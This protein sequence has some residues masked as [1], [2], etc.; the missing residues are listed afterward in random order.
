MKKQ[1][2]I[3]PSPLKR[4]KPVARGFF[5]AALVGA[6]A[7]RVLPVDGATMSWVQLANNYWD[8][9]TN[10]S[11][12]IVPGTNDVAIIN[13]QGGGSQN[14]VVIRQPV[15]V[16][17]LSLAMNVSMETGGSLTIA[18]GT[19]DC[20]MNTMNNQ[21]V[22]I[23]G[24][25]NIA[26]N[27]VLNVSV[28]PTLN[29]TLVNAGTVNMAASLMINSGRIINLPQA[30]F[31]MIG[32]LPVGIVSVGGVVDFSNAGVLR[33]S[34]NAE[35]AF[36]NQNFA[37]TNNGLVKVE[38]GR[39][40]I[41]GPGRSDG[42][43]DAATGAS[44]ELNNYFTFE[45]SHQFSGGGTNLWSS[46]EVWVYGELTG[47]QFLLGPGSTLMSATNNLGGRLI[48]TGGTIGLDSAQAL[49]IEPGGVLSIGGTVHLKGSITNAGTVVWSG[50]NIWLDSGSAAV[51]CNQ[52][53][54]VFELRNTGGLLGS[55][56]SLFYNA[57]LVR[58]VAVK[59]NTLIDG[60]RFVN[61]GTLEVVTG[62]LTVVGGFDGAGGV[63]TFGISSPTDYGWIDF[64]TGGN[65]PLAGSLS[66]NLLNGYEPDAGT[67]FPVVTFGSKSGAFT[68][69]T[70]LFVGSGR[71][72]E[73]VFTST[74]LNLVAH[75]T[76]FPAIATD[77][78]VITNGQCHFNYVGTP[79]RVCEVWVSTNLP[80]F[81]LLQ[82]L[83]NSTGTLP[84]TD[85]VTNLPQR[86]YQ[87]RE[88]Q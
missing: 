38:S 71:Y 39:L 73:P 11:P 88:Q 16:G 3:T 62:P 51:L 47:S 13:Y 37:F 23:T 57:G 53:Q 82:T 58:K 26:S 36:I 10:W 31:N 9:P 77:S 29:G 74:S 35:T 15:T 64:G 4:F 45:R 25:L 6:A 48:W 70:G 49:N 59:A 40:Q 22:T 68:N 17:G 20:G 7:M 69:T 84:I 52:S 1:H 42:V 43:F 81:Q 8:N 66:A 87:V 55:Y 85:A 21:G 63:M 86:F 5:L 67:S 27:A 33:K 60:V 12:R 44:I 30:N 50:G 65:A 32:D 79:G 24:N 76:N 46:C 18:N 72:F 54:G 80:Q 14:P 28:Y 75:T 19:M 56:P 41:L 34:G 61:A 78:L 83:T 2:E